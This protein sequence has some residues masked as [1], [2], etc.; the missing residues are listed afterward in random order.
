M[1]SGHY[2]YFIDESIKPKSLP[3]KTIPK[4]K[5]KIVYARVSSKKQSGDLER[6]VRYLKRLY[7]GHRIVTDIGSGINYKRKGFKAILEGLFQNKIKQVVVAHK[8]RFSRFGFDLFTWMFSQF[9]AELKTLEVTKHTE[10]SEELAQDLM[11]IITVFSARY[12]GQRKYS[13]HQKVKVLP[14][15]RAKTTIQ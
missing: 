4:D 12:Y 3:V 10:R 8:D 11:E 15:H 1:P 9:G 2:Q 5:S 6:Q 14:K 13:M 7:P